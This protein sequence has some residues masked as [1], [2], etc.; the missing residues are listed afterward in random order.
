MLGDA[1]EEVHLVEVEGGPDD[2]V[3][4]DVGGGWDAGDDEQVAEVAVDVGDIT[5]WL[6]GVDADGD[7]AFALIDGE[8]DGVVAQAGDD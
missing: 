2:V 5:S 3:G 6:D 8:L 7:G 4:F 1:V